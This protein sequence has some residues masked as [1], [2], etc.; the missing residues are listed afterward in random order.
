MTDL[1]C[2]EVKEIGLMDIIRIGLRTYQP[3]EPPNYKAGA[4]IKI[5]RNPLEE[6]T[7]K[8][9]EKENAKRTMAQKNIK[10]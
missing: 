4:T 2:D 1:I 10:G 5:R 9:L 8:Y 3:F 7:I 6:P